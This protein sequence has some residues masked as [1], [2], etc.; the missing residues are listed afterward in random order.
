MQDKLPVVDLTAEVTGWVWGC[1]GQAGG[2]LAHS[3]CVETLLFLICAKHADTRRCCRV[4]VRSG[5]FVVMENKQRGLGEPL[6]DP[7]RLSRGVFCRRAPP[8]DPEILR[9]MK[10][11]GFIGYAPNPRTKLRNQVPALRRAGALTVRGATSEL[12]VGLG[13]GDR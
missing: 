11:V 6:W 3:A 1:W 7:Q 5:H 9:T 8:V 13:V 2:I 12:P 10:K 4:L